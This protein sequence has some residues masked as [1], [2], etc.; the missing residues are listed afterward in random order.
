MNQVSALAGKYRNLQVAKGAKAGFISDVKACQYSTY[1]EFAGMDTDGVETEG[2]KCAGKSVPLTIMK[3]ALQILPDRKRNKWPYWRG[4]VCGVQVDEAEGKAFLV[5][6]LHPFHED[7][8]SMVVDLD[9]A[10]AEREL[11]P[12]PGLML[13][14]EWQLVT[15]KD[16]TPVNAKDAWDDELFPCAEFKDSENN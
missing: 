6:D 13:T 4:V 14:E 1:G 3:S 16:S 8:R 10:I 9:K 15:T 12:V 7:S 5:L 2:E 11:K